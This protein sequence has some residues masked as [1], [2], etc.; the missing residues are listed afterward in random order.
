MQWKW[1]RKK[2][3]QTIKKGVRKSC[4]RISPKLPE[5]ILGHF[6]WDFHV[7][8]FKSKHIGPFLSNQSKLGA[9]FARIFIEFAKIF[10][11]FSKVF[12]K[13]AQI[14]TEFSR[15]FRNFAQI[16][17]KS[18]NLGVCLHPRH[19]RL[20]HHWVTVVN[21]VQEPVSNHG[22]YDVIQQRWL[23]NFW[24]TFLA[25]SSITITK[26]T[27]SF[28]TAFQFNHFSPMCATYLLNFPQP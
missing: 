20:P 27:Y 25:S 11:D 15:I 5:E 19:P 1:L 24:S 10:K 3:M 8:F 2:E 18:K 13:F 22:R 12:T 9:I 17:T 6:L 21:T 7:I 28:I 14:S 26:K 4:D 23:A 16:F